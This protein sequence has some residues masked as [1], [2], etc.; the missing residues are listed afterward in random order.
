MTGLK[1][2]KKVFHLLQK[3][4]SDCKTVTIKQKLI[5][6]F[7]PFQ[8]MTFLDRHINATNLC[9]LVENQ[10]DQASGVQNS[11]FASNRQDLTNLYNEFNVF[12]IYIGQIYSYLFK[13]YLFLPDFKT[14]LKSVRSNHFV[15]IICLPVD[16]F[17]W[18]FVHLIVAEESC[19]E[20]EILLN[21]TD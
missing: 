19:V 6:C 13:T 15:L 18:L 8:L 2:P 1:F 5:S 14:W 10:H 11:D 20:Q 4:V 12:L 9:Q 17:P 16:Q 21:L 3:A 7:Y